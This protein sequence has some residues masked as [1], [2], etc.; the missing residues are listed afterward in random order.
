MNSRNYRN[1]PISSHLQ[2]PLLACLLATAFLFGSARSL[3]ASVPT[4]FQIPHEIQRSA[5]LVVDLNGDGVKELITGSIDGYVTVINGQTYSVM[6]DKNMADYLDGYDKTRI[7]SGLAAADLDGDGRIEIVVATGGADPINGDGPG[8]VIVFTYIGGDKWL[9]LKQGWPVLAFDELG[10]P[11]GR[12]DGHPDGFTSTPSLGDIDGDGDMEIVIGGMDRRLH[13]FH[14][15]GTY[16][17]GWPLY[18]DYGILRESRSTAAL[19]DLD[20]DNILDI[21]IGTNNYKIP[22][23]ANPYLFYAIKGDTT[24]IP[25]FPIETSQNIESSPAIGDINNDGSLDIVFGTGDFNE[26]CGQRSD[27]KK[28]YAVN[29]FG[30]PLPGWP[31]TTNANMLNSPALGDLDNDGAPEVVIH[32]RDTLYAWHGDGSLVQGFPVQGEFNL[33]HA[34]PVLADVDGDSQVEIVLASGQV[35]GPTGELEQQRNKLQSQV[36]VTDQDGDGLLET[37]GANHF[38]YS[39]GLHLYVYIFEEEGPATGAQ[40]WPMFHRT[41]D[42]N[43]MLPIL[44]TLR[45]RIVDEEN[46]GVANVKVTL[47]SGQVALTDARGNYVFG[48]MPPG[49]YVITPSYQDNLFVPEE[50]SVSLQGNMTVAD[51]V[52]H[53][54]VYDIYGS[55]LHANGKPMAGVTVQLSTGAKLTTGANGAFSFNDQDPGEYTLTP[56]SP[57]L[58]YVPEERIVQAEEK[59]PQIFYALPKPVMGTLQLTGTT[60]LKFD[61]TQGMPTSV[62]FP[63][64]LGEEEEAVITP[65]LPVIPS[66]FATTGHA[67]EIA[68]DSEDV[69]A[70][71]EIVGKDGEPLSIEIQIQY[72]P[73]DLP[74]FV[75]ASELVLLWESPDGWADADTACTAGSAIEHDQTKRVI[76]A[77]VCQWG[78][79]GL[80][81]PVDSLYF[82][83]LFGRP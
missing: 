29:R 81:I 2:I 48:S 35:Y 51:M 43:G 63:A 65:I 57:D 49:D 37:I 69:L 24:P 56:I 28:V 14:H 42:R 80:F 78:T 17:Q 44:Y 22:N 12:P 38:N 71:S 3:L 16:V 5:M 13:A 39:I 70:Q 54:P 33:R 47:N 73:A 1:V 62:T 74:S 30:Q 66:G 55:V 40:P 60:Q 58:V 8:A 32:T 26:N 10:G 20:G 72:S 25:G 83:H 45:G 82:P 18:R 9:E 67:F 19:A 52:M 34:T 6:W 61:D 21:I 41:L 50:L 76:T 77:S 59:I 23:C 75:D 4:T 7:Q 31:V 36:V 27:G 53:K 15:D 79:Y 46:R 11:G 64:G 68:L